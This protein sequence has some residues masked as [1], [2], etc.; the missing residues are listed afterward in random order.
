MTST[1]DARKRAFQPG[2]TKL[3]QPARRRQ[4]AAAARVARLSCRPM[5]RA[6]T[7]SPWLQTPCQLPSSHV[8]ALTESR[9]IRRRVAT[10][11]TPRGVPRY[12]R[13]CSSGPCSS[14][15]RY[16]SRRILRKA[17]R[18]R[19]RKRRCG[20]PS[21]R[22]ACGARPAVRLA[23]LGDVNAPA[24]VAGALDHSVRHLSPA[25][26]YTSPAVAA[27]NADAVPHCRTI[28]AIR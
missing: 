9:R 1:A 28:P 13:W 23:V 26:R 8:S 18:F 25:G 10:A 15:C 17:Y 16:G 14:Y 21:A 19:H 4:Q 6:C 7:A 3:S 24:S 11:R 27:A 22:G 12:C 2:R 20:S 5:L